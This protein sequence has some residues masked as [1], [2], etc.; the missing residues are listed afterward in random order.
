M[1]QCSAK[2]QSQYLKLGIPLCPLADTSRSIFGASVEGQPEVSHLRRPFTEQFI[3]CHFLKAFPEGVSSTEISLASE[4]EAGS[5]SQCL[6]AP[7][8]GIAQR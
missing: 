2:V 1:P 7:D 3:L 6:V 4:D 5:L 8:S